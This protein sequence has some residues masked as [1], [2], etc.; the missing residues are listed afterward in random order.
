MHWTTHLDT[1]TTA[2]APIKVLDAEIPEARSLVVSVDAASGYVTLDITTRSTS[3]RLTLYA[4]QRVVLDVAHVATARVEIVACTIAAASRG[5]VI[6][7]ASPEPVRISSR[8]WH[9][10]SLALDAEELAAQSINGVVR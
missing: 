1:L 7:L 5:R 9:Y 2:S 8:V 10:A 3:R 4:G 6:V